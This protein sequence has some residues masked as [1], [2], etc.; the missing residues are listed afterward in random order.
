MAAARR[1]IDFSRIC[2][3]CDAAPRIRLLG[4]ELHLKLVDGKAP[5]LILHSSGGG[6]AK[7]EAAAK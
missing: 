2:R 7:P 5:D 4:E 1:M 3:H 6:G